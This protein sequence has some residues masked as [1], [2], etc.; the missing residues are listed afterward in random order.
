MDTALFP[1]IPVSFKNCISSGKASYE[2]VM[3]KTG[4]E[5][6]A[7]NRISVEFSDDARC[8]GNACG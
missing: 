1:S 8:R 4:H 6:N 2:P 7:F 3:P 5:G